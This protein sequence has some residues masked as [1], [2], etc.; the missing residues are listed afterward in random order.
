MRRTLTLVSVFTLLLG[1]LAIPAMAAVVQ[2]DAVIASVSGSGDNDAP[3]W[4]EYGETQFNETWL[5]EKV[6]DEGAGTNYTL[7]DAPLP[8]YMWRLAVVKQATFNYLFFDPDIGDTFDT[9]GAYSH[10]ILCQMEIPYGAILVHKVDEE[11]ELLAG[12]G[13]T[14]TPG[15]IVMTETPDGVFCED[16]L[17]IVEYTVTETTIPNGYSGDAA[18]TVTPVPGT[19]CES[20]ELVPLEFENT[21]VPGDVY[22]EKFDGWGK[23]LEGVT[24]SLTD[25]A[26]YNETCTTDA[27]GKCGFEDVPLGTYT[28]DEVVPMGYTIGAVTLNGVLLPAGLPHTFDI[29]LGEAPETGQTFTFSV[30]NEFGDEWCSPGFWSQNPIAAAEAAAAGGFSLD[31]LYSDFFDP[32]LGLN[33]KQLAKQ[34]LTT[35]PTL[36]EVLSYPQVY[37]G[38]AFNNV[39]DL[40]SDAHPDVNFAYDYRVED[41]CPLAADAS[42]T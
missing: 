7:L 17:P 35:E 1:M 30:V 37:G 6:D 23:P 22:I 11:G 34:G 32:I 25:G 21:P 28:L 26:D 31:D 42:R 3:Y 15:D 27:L 40:L 18:K 4:E 20:M 38:E 36:W 2:P 9:G 13:F 29:G 33:E 8:G 19:T 10:V 41:S 14:I 39:G 24:F 16:E 5:C 12:A